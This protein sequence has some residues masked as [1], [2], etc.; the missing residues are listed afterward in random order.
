ML[1]AKEIETKSF[2]KTRA[3]Y[4]PDEVDNF[5]D[6]IL[7]D[8]D[9]FTEVK[10]HLE[11]KIETLNQTIEELKKTKAS[12]AVNP[13]FSSSNLIENAQIKAEKLVNDAQNY[14]KKLIEAAKIEAD[15]QKQRTERLNKEVA[16][17]KTNLLT[18]YENHVKL[19]SSIPEIKGFS[20]E[21]SDSLELLKSAT[22][23]LPEDK[24]E[25]ADENTVSETGEFGE[26]L[27]DSE[28]EDGTELTFDFSEDSDLEHIIH[29]DEEDVQIRKAAEAAPKRRRAK[30]VSEKVQE[31]EEDEDYIDFDDFDD[32]DEK[33]TAFGSLFGGKKE[34][35]EKEKKK[36][37]HFFNVVDDD[38]DY[39]DDV[40][41]DDD[42]F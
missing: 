11:Q 39:D 41:D 37:R 18:I 5:L 9:R 28:P 34:K 30:M 2:S 31:P 26:V 23:D 13:A 1:T 33:G 40:F 19:I 42:D 35:K 24:P 27:M 15:N 8:Y 12:P 14:A 16:D 10:V 22:I 3:G 20:V 4:S 32:E 29:A 25:D 17:F 21:E 36:K 38:D 6:E 7:Q